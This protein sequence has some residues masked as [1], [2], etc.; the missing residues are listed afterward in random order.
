M[1]RHRRYVLLWGLIPPL[2]AGL[3]MAELTLGTVSLSL[4]QIGQAIDMTHIVPRS[5]VIRSIVLDIRLP[6]ALLAMLTGAGL[7]M[8]GALLQTVTRNDLADPF[9]FGLSSGASA[10]AVWV[11]TRLGDQLGIWT[12]PLA[13]FAGGALSSA[14]VILIFVL[15][16]HKGTERLV[17][18]GLAISF[19]FSALTNYFIFTGDQRAAG[20]VLFWSLGGLGLASWNNIGI[21]LAAVSLLAGV[22]LFRLRSLDSLLSGEQTAHSLGIPV[23][24]L[25]I[26]IFISCAMAT[27]ALVAL[28]GVIG[29]IGLMVPHLVRPFSGVRHGKL[30]P[31]A[32]CIGAL[33]LL[34]GDI[35]SR[36]LAAPQELPIGIITGSLGGLFVL[37]MLLRK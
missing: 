27:S 1:R 22:I 2:L 14:T 12:L 13:S 6:R 20:S 33:L 10:G 5:A 26:E 3:F 9:L 19:L 30:L 35:L 11:I 28:T 21:A 34:T 23:T 29:F 24:R 8:V 32:A 15:Q 36:T 25:R 4:A 31:L 18:S 7:A 37:A 17:V 16:S